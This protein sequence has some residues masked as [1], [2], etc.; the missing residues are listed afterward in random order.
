MEEIEVIMYEDKE[1]TR[2][3]IGD[4]LTNGKGVEG[5]LGNIGGVAMFIRR[6]KGKITQ[7]TV[8]SKFSFDHFTKV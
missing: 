4:R 3:K 8:L 7:T 1:G 2:L 6:T 5:Q